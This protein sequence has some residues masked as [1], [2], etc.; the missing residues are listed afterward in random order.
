MKSFSLVALILFVL[1]IFKNKESNNIEV[2]KTYPDRGDKWKDMYRSID[3]LSDQKTKNVFKDLMKYVE[4]YNK[5]EGKN[6]K[7]F[8]TRRPLNRQKR[9]IKAGYSQVVDVYRAPHV[10]GRAIDIVE[11]VNG[12]WI[13][14]HVNL[15]KLNEYLYRNFPGF[16]LLRTGRDFKT[17][18]DYP[19]YEIKRNIW[20]SWQ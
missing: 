12:V 6:F 1:G 13:W 3:D 9:V 2:K 19:H 4:K 20:E 7:I 14:Q 11:Y 5:K 15:K 10:E 16:Y 8:E 18:K 17:F